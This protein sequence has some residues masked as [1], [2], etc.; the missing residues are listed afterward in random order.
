MRVGNC[1]SEI[2]KEG[3]ELEKR[4]L[5]EVFIKKRLGGK[6]VF[7]ETEDRRR[8]FNVEG[9][10]FFGWRCCRVFLKIKN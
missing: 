9:E 7:V 8:L 4:F 1:V 5:N 10:I 2:F 3:F 6:E